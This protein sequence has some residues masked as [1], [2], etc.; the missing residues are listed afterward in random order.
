[1][2]MNFREGEVR[3]K[4]DVSSYAGWKFWLIG[5]LAMSDLP[6]FICIHWS[7]SRCITSMYALSVKTC[8]LERTHAMP[9][10][11]EAEGVDKK[12]R[13]QAG[14]ESG[15]WPITP[16]RSPIIPR[17]SILYSKQQAG[18]TTLLHRYSVV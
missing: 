7:N 9:L 15:S 11:I 8:V 16:R 4:V 2:S 13:F 12:S 10:R 17:I 5:A 18:S 3:T 14:K 1:M 6:C